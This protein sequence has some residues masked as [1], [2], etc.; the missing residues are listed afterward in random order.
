M[1]KFTQNRGG[2]NFKEN[3]TITPNNG[4]HAACACLV[5]DPAQKYPS[6][7]SAQKTL[8]QRNES[9]EFHQSLVFYASESGLVIRY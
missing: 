6:Q 3:P 5:E 1:L 2:G 7:Q 9:A 4:R 8:P